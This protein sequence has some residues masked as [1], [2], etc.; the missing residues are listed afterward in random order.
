MIFILLRTLIPAQNSPP[1]VYFVC[2]EADRQ[3]VTRK[4]VLLKEKQTDSTARE[5][6]GSFTVSV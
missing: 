5:F 4:I 2:L 1:G 6:C 3:D